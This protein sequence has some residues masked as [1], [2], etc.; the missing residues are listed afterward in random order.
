MLAGIWAC[1][2]KIDSIRYFASFADRPSG[3]AQF[4]FSS[5]KATS[6]RTMYVAE[7]HLGIRQVHF[8]D[9]MPPNTDKGVSGLWWRTFSVHGGSGLRV[10]TD[11]LKIRR[12]V[13]IPGDVVSHLAENIA[14]LTPEPRPD[15]IRFHSYTL[16]SP[17]QLRMTSFT[18]NDSRATAYSACWDGCIL[19]LH[20]HTVS[21]SQAF[22]NDVLRALDL[23]MKT[24]KC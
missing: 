16:N 22:Y 7:D 11:G 14:W 15:L 4:I 6:V 2:I 9:S 17:T 24:S 12:F 1:Y 13:A 8:S 21:E 10:Y 3:N 20:T 5:E 23:E 19:Y 18:C